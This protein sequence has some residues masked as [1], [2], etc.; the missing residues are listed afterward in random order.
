MLFY[1]A[2]GD[3]LIYQAVSTQNK[4]AAAEIEGSMLKNRPNSRG[5]ASIT[6]FASDGYGGFVSTSRPV[7][8]GVTINLGSDTH[9]PNES[10]PGTAYPNPLNPATLMPIERTV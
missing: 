5:S 1:D 8:V 4:I 10:Q 2:D 9:I 6:V 7:N 3:S